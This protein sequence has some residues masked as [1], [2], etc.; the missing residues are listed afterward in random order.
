VALDLV[1]FE[2]PNKRLTFDS[3]ENEFLTTLRGLI[4]GNEKNPSESNSA[5]H[6]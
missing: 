3:D 2:G 1:E 5:P 6:S 4:S